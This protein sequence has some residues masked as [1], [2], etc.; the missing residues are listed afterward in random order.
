[1]TDYYIILDSGHKHT[2]K[3]KHDLKALIKYILTNPAIMINDNH[4][5][6]TKHIARV[7]IHNSK[8][9]DLI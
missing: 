2:I 4:A 5:I 3:Y 6:F 1:M 7:G 8:E 9:Q